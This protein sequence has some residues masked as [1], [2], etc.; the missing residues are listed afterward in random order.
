MPGIGLTR[1]LLAT[2][3]RDLAALLRSQHYLLVI[4]HVCASSKLQNKQERAPPSGTP[5]HLFLRPPEV[6]PNLDLSSYG[7]LTEPY[8]Q[9]KREKTTGHGLR[10]GAP[11][12]AKHAIPL[13]QPCRSQT[14]DV[15]ASHPASL[16]GSPAFPSELPAQELGPRPG[17]QRWAAP[18]S[19]SNRSCPP[20]KAALCRALLPPR[21]PAWGPPAEPMAK[22]GWQRRARAPA[23]C[24]GWQQG[25]KLAL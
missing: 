2:L 20:S 14:G 5:P 23:G 16:P 15:T 17:F 12:R 6:P 13:K 19:R 1:R 18:P 7:S 24:S 8:Y 4:Q 22:R 10:E 21:D 9:G 11:L 25:E 3:Q